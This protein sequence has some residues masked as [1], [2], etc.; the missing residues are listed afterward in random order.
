MLVNFTPD[1]FTKEF[2]EIFLSS[3]ESFICKKKLAT[4]LAF[5]LGLGYYY[6]YQTKETFFSGCVEKNRQLLPP[7]RKKG[8]L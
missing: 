8:G 7:F 6:Y 3:Y 5:L 4:T 2:G 1:P